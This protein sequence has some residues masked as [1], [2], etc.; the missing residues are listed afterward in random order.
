M[1][2]WQLFLERQIANILC[3]VSHCV[4]TTQLCCCR[5]AA[6]DHT[7]MNACKHS[8]VPKNVIYKSRWLAHRPRLLTSVVDSRICICVC[9]Y[10]CVCV[11]RCVHKIHRRHQNYM[12]IYEVDNG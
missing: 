9:A 11:H 1:R 4:T 5:K 2:G 6:I 7:E 3:F 10:I 12:C 8:C